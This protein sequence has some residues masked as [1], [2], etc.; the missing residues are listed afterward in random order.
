MSAKKASADLEALRDAALSDLMSA[1][2]ADLRQ[3]ATEDG[4]DIDSVAERISTSV[5]ETIAWALRQRLV[6]AKERMNASN[7]V[8]SVPQRLPS[9]E[10]IKDALMCRF[11]DDPNLSLAFRDGKTP[12]DA[13]W[14][15]LYEDLIAMGAFRP[16]KDGV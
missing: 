10:I 6:R 3:E 4:E 14:I 16:D 11:R 2:D 15:S 5:Q 13:D 1:T 8:C 12:T 7:S 9:V